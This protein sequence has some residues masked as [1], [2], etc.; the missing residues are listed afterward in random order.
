MLIANPIYDS[1]FKYL[2]EDMEIARR[3]LSI[4]MGE[5]I[6]EISVKP[7]EKIGYSDKYLMT[8]FRVDFNAVVKMADGSRKKIIIELQKGKNAF[9][10]MRFRRYLG[11]SYINSDAVDGVKIA[12]PI[13]AIYFLGFELSIKRA[14][15]K[16]GRTYLD[17]RNGESLFQKDDFIEKLTHDCYVI[18]IPSLPKTTQSELEKVLSVFDQRFI[19]DNRKA[20]LD[21]KAVADN[22]TQSL[23]I[24]RLINAASSSEV[25]AQVI[26]EEEVEFSIEQALRDVEIKME[27]KEKEIIEK[28]KRIIEKDKR[29][30]EKDKRI[31]DLIKELELLKSKK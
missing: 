15:L 6:V 20:F 29:I 2:M 8:I 3:L 14:I 7:Q 19:I 25:Q 30:I 4:I 23:M 17:M 16:I 13:V 24:K 31:E 10:V 21:Y 26:M 22:E 18:Q 9:D 28:D 5:E 27:A 11:D 1:V 12:I